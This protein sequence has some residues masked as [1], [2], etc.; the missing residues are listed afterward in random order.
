M[1]SF[2]R[3]KAKQFGNDM[4]ISKFAY[5]N[6][7]LVRFNTRHMISCGVIPGESKGIYH[8]LIMKG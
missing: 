1:T 3:S 8:Q 5:L 2:K 7:C 6:G 4:G